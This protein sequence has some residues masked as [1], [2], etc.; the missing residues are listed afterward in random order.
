MSRQLFNFFTDTF[1]IQLIYFIKNINLIMKF[2]MKYFYFLNRDYLCNDFKVKKH[3]LKIL[4]KLLI[5][6][7]NQF[8]NKKSR[9]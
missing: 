9:A 4:D 6:E 1:N 2:L 8:F 7:K 5:L 3:N